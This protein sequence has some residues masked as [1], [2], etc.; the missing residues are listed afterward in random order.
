VTDRAGRA[1]WTL[2]A[3]DL[4]RIAGHRLT[5]DELEH[6]G[7]AIAHSSIPQA[8]EEVIAALADSTSP[9]EEDERTAEVN[10][11]LRHRLSWEGQAAQYPPTGEPG[12]GYFAGDAG[13][14]KPVDCLLRRDGTGL[15]R[16]I[17][18]HYP[19]DMPPWEKAGNVT[20][21]VQPGWRRN[22]IASALLDEARRRW[23]IDLTAQT[24]T[25]NGRRFIAAYRR[26][27]EDA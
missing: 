26:R 8:L 12:I 15:L 14:N 3:A 9:I 23:P 19:V 7:R 13:Y 16:G 21:L 4:D 24:Y 10:P 11:D 22:G 25:D 6:I 17:L 5:D 2:T 20:V 27:R 18:N 1:V